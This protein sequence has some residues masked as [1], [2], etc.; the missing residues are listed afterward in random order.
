MDVDEAGRDQ[1]TVG[2]EFAAPSAIE[3]TIVEVDDLADTVADD[4]DIGASA[5]RAGSVD[6]EPVANDGVVL[7]AAS[8]L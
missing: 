8:S 4:A 2:I 1:T 3:T 6:D 7:H 5:G